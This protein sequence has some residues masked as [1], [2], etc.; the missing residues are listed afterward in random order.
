MKQT[1]KCGEPLPPEV[2]AKIESLKLVLSESLPYLTHSATL[3]KDLVPW[4]EAL[5]QKVHKVLFLDP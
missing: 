3:S 1:C 4:S 5:V 2:Q